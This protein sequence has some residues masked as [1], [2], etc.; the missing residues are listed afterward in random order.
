MTGLIR[1]E[2]LKIRT[3]NTWWLFGLGVILMTALALLV[4]C[5][6]AD[7]FL[8]QEP[9]DTTGMDPEDAARTR[10]QFATQSQVVG[11]AANIFTSGQFFGGLFILLL[12][13]LLI[14]NEFYHQTATATFLTT[15]HREA[16]VVAKLVTGVFFAAVFWVVTTLMSLGVGVLF[17]QAQD[18]PNHL[19]DWQVQRAI[20][21]NLLV[22]GLWAILGVGFG[23]LIRNQIG[24]VVTGTLL[25]LIGTQLAQI[26][27]FLV[28]EFLI[29]DDRVF[30]WQVV[31]PATA[32]QIFTSAV[33][34]F[35]ESPPY[36]VG[37]LVMLGYG[38][39]GGFIGTLIM[40]RRDIS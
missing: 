40:R 12:G 10:E 19:G 9:P 38:V 20:L 21:F 5:L 15:P 1:S 16:V 17:F 27:F 18:V 34:V 11:Q 3:T 39:V 22:Y 25:Y 29:K 28:R 24:A 33:D 30:A 36:W 13:M 31:I 37:G 32:A 7:F 4:N 2:L 8:S 6:Q 35:P 23:A 14:T 26:I